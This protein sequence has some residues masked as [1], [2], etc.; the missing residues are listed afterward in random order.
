MVLEPKFGRVLQEKSE[1]GEDGHPVLVVDP[2]KTLQVE[3]TGNPMV[4]CF[5]SF[6]T[7]S[8]TEDNPRTSRAR[9]RDRNASKA[10]QA[11]L[12]GFL[13]VLR[14]E[15]RSLALVHGY[16]ASDGNGCA[17]KGGPAFSNFLQDLHVITE[18]PVNFVWILD[19]N[20]RPLAFLLSFAG[21]LPNAFLQ[22]L[23]ELGR[24]FRINLGS[25]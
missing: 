11:V 10:F 9:I 17:S 21:K 13:W 24:N 6:T 19:N 1:A 22:D 25:F 7:L 4:G 2:S 23:C 8:T 20:I 14:V 12:K 16:D 5:G 15:M 3:S 18:S